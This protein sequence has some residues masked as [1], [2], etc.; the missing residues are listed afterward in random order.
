MGPYTGLSFNSFAMSS[1]DSGV[2]GSPGTGNIAH[3]WRSPCASAPTVAIGGG[4]EPGSRDA[5][6]SCVPSLPVVILESAS[7]TRLS[8]PFTNLIVISNSPSVT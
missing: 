3:V 2:V 6:S 4:N 7:G 5:S 1:R 8:F